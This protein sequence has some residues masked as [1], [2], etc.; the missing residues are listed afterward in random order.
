[1][2]RNPDRKYLIKIIDD[3]LIRTTVWATLRNGWKSSV[4]GVTE[5]IDDC[6]E[7]P[8][9]NYMTYQLTRSI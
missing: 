4:R 1:M 3:D 7:I 6:N 8:I 5:V 2:Q 9:I